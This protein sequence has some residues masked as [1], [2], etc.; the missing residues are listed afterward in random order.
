MSVNSAVMAARASSAL[1]YPTGLRP[2]GSP[3]RALTRTAHFPS[4]VWYSCT[5]PH[6]LP[7]RNSR[8]SDLSS[9]RDWANSGR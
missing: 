7:E 4:W 6:E 3:L 2:M 5:R 8:P 1:S 9:R